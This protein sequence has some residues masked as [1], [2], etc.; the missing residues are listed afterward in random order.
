MYRRTTTHKK[1][2][3]SSIEFLYFF[4][5]D[6]ASIHIDLGLIFTLVHNIMHRIKFINGA[7]YYAWRCTGRFPFIWNFFFRISCESIGTPYTLDFEQILWEYPMRTPLPKSNKLNLSC[8]RKINLANSDHN[9]NRIR[10]K[11]LW[12]MRGDTQDKLGRM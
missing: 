6:N 4:I 8:W 7:W 5:G 11:K 10:G 1:V 3:Q 2:F 9:A 12:E